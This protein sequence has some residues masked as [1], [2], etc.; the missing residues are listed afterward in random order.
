MLIEA[1]KKKLPE[2]ARVVLKVIFEK[3]E[4][5]QNLSKT[6]DV[7]SIY[8]VLVTSIVFSSWQ[9]NVRVKKF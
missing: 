5:E 8:L 2:N 9:L 1:T 3:L 7:S 4:K 6:S